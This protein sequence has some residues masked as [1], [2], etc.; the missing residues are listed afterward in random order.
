MRTA[1]SRVLTAGALVLFCL[2]LAPSRT[3]AFGEDGHRGIYEEAIK[4]LNV[5]ADLCCEKWQNAVFGGKPWRDWRAKS[6][7]FPDYAITLGYQETYELGPFEDP[8]TGNQLLQKITITLTPTDLLDSLNSAEH[9]FD[10]RAPKTVF[11][12][13]DQGAFRILAESRLTKRVTRSWPISDLPVQWSEAVRNAVFGQMKTQ[14]LLLFVG[15]LV[16]LMVPD[17]GSIPRLEKTFSDFLMQR[18]GVSETGDLDGKGYNALTSILYFLNGT[19]NPKDKA[20]N[21]TGRAPTRGF[22]AL[23]KEGKIADA[24]LC[25]GIAIH[26]VA[27]FYS[28]GHTDFDSWPL[29]AHEDFDNLG[30]SFFYSE[31][32]ELESIF[33]SRPSL[34]IRKEWLAQRLADTSPRLI[35]TFDGTLDPCTTKGTKDV[36]YAR[37]SGIWREDVPAVLLSEAEISR[38]IW[39][40][41]QEWLRK[42]KSEAGVR[43]FSYRL[44]DAISVCAGIIDWAFSSASRKADSVYARD[45]PNFFGMA[46][47]LFDNP[48]AV[49]RPSALA[50]GPGKWTLGYGERLEQSPTCHLG[51]IDQDDY[52]PVTACTSRYIHVSVLNDQG[53][54]DALAVKKGRI[55]ADIVDVEG[56]TVF[57]GRPAE[58]CLELDLG[59]PPLRDDF[60]LRVYAPEADELTYTVTIA[61]PQETGILVVTEPVGARVWVSGDEVADRVTPLE[62]PLPTDA[63]RVT[64]LVEKQGFK[65]ASKAIEIRPNQTTAVEFILE[66]VADQTA[67]SVTTVPPGAT[68]SLNGKAVRG[69]LTPNIFLVGEDIAEV[70]RVAIGVD[71][72]GYSPQTRHV[73]LERHQVARAA[74]D[75]KEDP[76]LTRIEIITQPS[77][78][79]AFVNHNQVT[80]GP[81]PVTVP[82]PPE[83][84]R[85]GEVEVSAVKAYRQK[86]TRVVK[87]QRGRTTRVDLELPELA[88]GPTAV[89]LLTTPPGA[90]VYINGKKVYRQKTP[91]VF[92]VGPENADAPF[93]NVVAELPGYE[94]AKRRVAIQ[95]GK[96]SKIEID[97]SPATPSG[98][99][100]VYVISRPTGVGVT[101]LRGL[102]RAS[103][104][105]PCQIDVPWHLVSKSGNVDVNV[106]TAPRYYRRRRLNRIPM[107]EGKVQRV[108]IVLEKEHDRTGVEIQTDPPGATA[109][110]DAKEVGTTPC[111]IS[112][113]LWK[114]NSEEDPPITSHEVRVNVKKEGYEPAAKTVTLSWDQ[115]KK[116][117]LTLKKIVR[118]GWLEVISNPPG[119]TV[120]IQNRSVDAVTPFVEELTPG[121]IASETVSVQVQLDGH[122]AEERTVHVAE[123]EAAQLTVDLDPLPQDSPGVEDGSDESMEPVDGQSG[124]RV[125]IEECVLTRHPQ[126]CSIVAFGSDNPPIPPLAYMNVQGVWVDAIIKNATSRRRGMVME[127]A[128]LRDPRG[129]DHA[130]GSLPFSIEAG[131]R[132]RHTL[133]VSP[134]A[135]IWGDVPTGM[136][137]GRLI[138]RETLLGP[139]HDQHDFELFVKAKDEV[140]LSGTIPREP[141]HNIHFEPL[142]KTG[143]EWY[144]D[145]ITVMNSVMLAAAGYYGVG[146]DGLWESTLYDFLATRSEL[147]DAATTTADISLAVSAIDEAKHRIACRW[148]NKEVVAG[149]R[150]IVNC[151]DRALIALHVPA[152][153]TVLDAPEELACSAMTSDGTR[154]AI[155]LTYPFVDKLL[156]P[157]PWHEN[158]ILLDVSQA[159]HPDGYVIQAS[160]ALQYGPFQGE[161]GSGIPDRL[162]DSP[163]IYNY[164]QWQREP[165]SLYWYTVAARAVS[166]EGPSVV[167]DDEPVPPGVTT[168]LLDVVYCVDCSGSMQDD[169]DAVKNDLNTAIGKTVADCER[170][171]I[172]LQMGLVTY[173][174]RD[175][176]EKSEFGQK[177]LRAWPMTENIEQV[178]Q[179]I[180]A[181]EVL[182]VA[183]G[184]GGNEDMYAALLCGM[185]ARDLMTNAV[186]RGL[187]A[188]PDGQGNLVDMGW[189]HGACKICIPIGDEPPSDPDWRGRTENTVVER[190]INLD[191]VHMY[192]L[193]VGSSGSR[194]TR[195]MKRL[196]R[197]TGGKV[198]AVKN[199]ADLPAAIDATLQQAIA[200]YHYEI[201]K[202]EHPPNMGLA[203]VLWG[204]G[205]FGVL[206]AILAGYH[207]VRLRVSGGATR[208]WLQIHDTRGGVRVQMLKK[209]TTRIGGAR[210]NDLVLRDERA[211]LHHAEI[212]VQEGCLT[213]VA[214]SDGE[215][216][217]VGGTAVSC[218]RLIADD[219][220]RIGDTMLLLASRP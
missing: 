169:I 209:D 204:T 142:S 103:G 20:Q 216:V 45:A 16:P 156:V 11:E 50:K 137:R 116:V 17:D 92:P 200:D 171:G 107:A 65:R 38:G 14:L 139:V 197:R 49:L 127:L 214:L 63:G 110:V 219:R 66:P 84:L 202:M 125:F 151:Y 184:A 188:Q 40:A 118:P 154:T 180:Q 21:P 72:A 117:H 122:R 115:R 158:E 51:G 173:T 141:G 34:T 145:A 67:V 85:L 53:E 39:D 181:I 179:N 77:G 143:A 33:F 176:M 152:D 75:L 111:S 36:A 123:A 189:R 175:D 95:R 165:E 163:W 207:V 37:G 217:Y 119:A 155:L 170:Q 177:W 194:A 62:H 78:A 113:F 132:Q 109:F 4:L 43:K 168:G 74:F 130:K 112:I 47:S 15:E 162:Q 126:M 18:S 212:R 41:K 27:D 210:D 114:L 90:A 193:I 2:L 178:K 135:Q 82:V 70:G 129:N 96:V 150:R 55:K 164:A 160:V 153:I 101:V 29:L 30:D 191:P 69:K 54:S 93:V 26:Y 98:D 94:R 32:S 25:L 19:G 161:L 80:A 203:I 195:S 60:L 185:G 196:A 24:L 157:G 99:T 182:G 46:T 206:L 35:L 208:F 198:L 28:P 159:D 211:A 104:T 106:P 86:A 128:H 79:T 71:L 44:A 148:R 174:R 121:E 147:N 205:T 144:Q 61:T 146:I 192:P 105:T 89:E 8:L 213:L 81:T 58:T 23:A 124:D 218:R 136:W 201:W 10:P 100:G 187:Y 73:P 186:F 22:V 5:D 76:G 120:R 7:N 172:S 88:D 68:V 9:Y 87:V 183:A 1:C 13:L 149:D 48:K 59:D 57:R 6:S 140:F 102:F 215:P 138:V 56:N 31:G 167:C 133:T 3:Y 131:E 52:F 12:E 64:V 134:G 97:L 83:A 91:G 190:S 42:E 108:E 166:A 220:I 199:A